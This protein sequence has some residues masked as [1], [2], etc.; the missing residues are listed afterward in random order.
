MQDRGNDL[1][2]AVTSTDGGGTRVGSMEILD[3]WTILK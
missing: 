2:S 3:A 1:K